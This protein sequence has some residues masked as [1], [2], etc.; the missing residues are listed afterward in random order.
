MKSK[1]NHVVLDTSILIALER[2]HLDIGQVLS[3]NEDYILTSIAMAE[4]MAGMASIS[5]PARKEK[6]A[7]KLSV[8]KRF[9]ETKVFGEP[10]AAEFAK[11]S[12]FTRLQNKRRTQFDLAMAAHAL[13]ENAIILTRDSRAAFHEL[14]GVQVRIV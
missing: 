1:S 7:Q 5:S 12:A 9:C 2:G 11:L 4:F 13:V 6:A 8:I 10:E 3:D 14:P